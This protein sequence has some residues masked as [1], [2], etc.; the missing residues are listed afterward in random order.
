[1]L[2]QCGENLEGKLDSTLKGIGPL[3]ETLKALGKEVKEGHLAQIRKDSYFANYIQRCITQG[4]LIESESQRKAKE[5]LKNNFFGI[6]EWAMVPGTALTDVN[7]DVIRDFPWSMDVLKSPDKWEPEKTIA[8]THFG[9]LGKP[10]FFGDKLTL[11]QWH[12]M[13]STRL[14]GPIYTLRI[15]QSDQRIWFYEEEWPDFDYCDL[16]WYLIRLIPVKQ[17]KGL[18]FEKQSSLIPPEYEIP[19]VID[20]FTKFI[21]HYLKNKC[22]PKGEFVCCDTLKSSCSGPR[23]KPSVQNYG[24]NLSIRY[25]RDDSGMPFGVSRKPGK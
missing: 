7:V 10:T 14:L 21:L 18:T 8:Q 20:E 6:K 5:I 4:C 1:M 24:P 19:C 17:F 9:F 11:R 16:R 2:S 23:F 15:N 12:Y 3:V 25:W 22:L 13:I